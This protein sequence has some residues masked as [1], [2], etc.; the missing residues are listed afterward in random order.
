M[1]YERL[2]PFFFF[3]QARYAQELI[4][5]PI[6]YAISTDYQLNGPIGGR[7]LDPEEIKKEF[8]DQTFL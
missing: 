5:L 7:L 2:A 4:W 1:P 3:F 8:L 6:Q